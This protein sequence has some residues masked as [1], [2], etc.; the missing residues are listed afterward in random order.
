MAPTTD[1][2]RAGIR[3]LST[4]ESV[5]PSSTRPD[6]SVRKEIRVKPGYKPPEDVEVYK[7]RTAHAFKNRG[8]GGVVGAEAVEEEKAPLSAAAGKNAKRREARKKAAAAGE[9]KDDGGEDEGA[10]DNAK[11]SN[12]EPQADT[13]PK[14]QE[15]ADV[16]PEVERAKEARKLAKKLR[17]ARELKDKLASVIKIQELIRQLDNL[18]FDAEGQKKDEQGALP[19]RAKE[20]AGETAAG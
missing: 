5:I 20:K 15:P 3:K 17:Q 2:S 4:G 18:G 1:T 7:N 11:V 9:G 19:K 10:A 14:P 12:G 6:G 13:A 16:D 8:K